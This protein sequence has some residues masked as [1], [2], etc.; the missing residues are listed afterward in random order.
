MLHGTVF[1]VALVFY[2]IHLEPNKTMHQVLDAFHFDRTPKS[3]VMEV[4][5]QNPLKE[6]EVKKIFA[7]VVDMFQG[8]R[9]AR[10]FLAIVVTFFLEW[11]PLMIGVLYQ[12][13]THKA[14]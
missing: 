3:A 5:V 1:T 8:N 7:D 11:A 14:P 2:K 4:T 9:I 10:R 6:V 12:A 13:F